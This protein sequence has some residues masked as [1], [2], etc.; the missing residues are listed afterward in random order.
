MHGRTGNLDLVKALQVG[1]DSVCPE[2]IV[3]PQIKDLADYRW[4]CRSG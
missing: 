1:S 4:R 3:L 2:V